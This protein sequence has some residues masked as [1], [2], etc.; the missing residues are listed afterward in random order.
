MYTRVKVF[1]EDWK[2]SQVSFFQLLCS[3]KNTLQNVICLLIKITIFVKCNP[4]IIMCYWH[5][6]HPLLQDNLGSSSRLQEYNQSIRAFPNILEYI[7]KWTHICNHLH[8]QVWNYIG[9]HL[10][11]SSPFLIPK[12]CG[13]GEGVIHKTKLLCEMISLLVAL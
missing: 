7:Y 5:L 4:Q 11:F 12:G 9:K 3:I 8:P 2:I 1:S 6:N 10:L 13:M